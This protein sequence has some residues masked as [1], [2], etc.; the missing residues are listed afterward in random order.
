MDDDE[1]LSNGDVYFLASRV[2]EGIA[3][4]NEARRLIA[5][6]V[7]KAARPKQVDERLIE[8]VRECFAAFLSGDARSLDKAFGLIRRKRGQPELDEQP[9]MDAAAMVLE[10]RLAGASHQEALA[11]VETARREAKLPVS[12]ESQIGGAWRDYKRDALLLC[13]LRRWERGEAWTP[14]EIKR[15]RLIFA[16]TKGII[17]PGDAAK[18]SGNS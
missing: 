1:L 18:N 4:P 7:R 6:F 9:T 8:H 5:E 14:T 12:S 17:F 11:K 16:K 10:A 13:R 2:I 15:L 3:T